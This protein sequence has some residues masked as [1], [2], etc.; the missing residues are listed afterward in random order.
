M[1]IL[2]RDKKWYWGSKGPFPSRKK[3]EKVAQAAHASGYVS[4]FLDFAIL[5][6]AP[7]EGVEGISGI[8]D[9][10]SDRPKDDVP[11]Q[12]R[13][14]A[15][16]E[17]IKR[18]GL[19]P[20][21]GVEEGTFY[22][23]R[24]LEAGQYAA[25][26]GDKRTVDE[27]REAGDD[28]SISLNDL[29]IK[30][31]DSGLETEHKYDKDSDEAEQRDLNRSG[32]GLNPVRNRRDI[33]RAMADRRYDSGT[34]AGMARRFADNIKMNKHP[35]RHSIW[36]SVDRS[37]TYD[38]EHYGDWLKAA[39]DKDEWEDAI[40]NAVVRILGR[41]V[42]RN[43]LMSDLAGEL[44][45]NGEQRVAKA[46]QQ[47][48]QLDKLQDEIKAFKIQRGIDRIGLKRGEKTVSASPENQERAKRFEEENKGLSKEEA[49]TFKS[50]LGKYL[51][52]TQERDAMANNYDHVSNALI[53]IQDAN[54]GVDSDDVSNA[55][56]YFLN[57][58]GK[59]GH[60]EQA[61]EKRITPEKLQQFIDEVQ[62]MANYT[63][64][65]LPEVVKV[66]RGNKAE[67]EKGD[68]KS[69]EASAKVA[70]QRYSIG[71][72]V[73]VTIHEPTAK[74]FGTSDGNRK[75]ILHETSIH[76]DDIISDMRESI[77]REDELLISSDVWKKSLKHPSYKASG[78]DP[79]DGTHRQ[80]WD[81]WPHRM[82]HRSKMNPDDP[83]YSDSYTHQQH[84]LQRMH[85]ES[86]KD[87]KH[88]FHKLPKDLQDDIADSAKLDIKESKKYPWLKA[89]EEVSD[90]DDVD[91]SLY[92]L[93]GN[94]LSSLL[95]FVILSKAPPFQVS[96][97]GEVQPIKPIEGIQHFDLD[98]QGEEHSE[99]VKVPEKY[100]KY[101]QSGDKLPDEV[102]FTYTG[103]RQGTFYDMRQLS[104]ESFDEEIN[105]IIEEYRTVRQEF[106][107][108]EYA[109][110]SAAKKA[111]DKDIA[112][113][114]RKKSAEEFKEQLSELDSL[115]D[116]WNSL[117]DDAKTAGNERELRELQD[118]IDALLLDKSAMIAQTT[119]PK[120][121]LANE[122]M[123]TRDAQIAKR[124]KTID[125]V[126][127]RLGHAMLYQAIRTGWSLHGE[128]IS[129]DPNIQYA[130]GEHFEKHLKDVMEQ[131]QGD[132]W[133][134]D[135][136]EIQKAVMTDSVESQ[137]G[138]MYETHTNTMIIGP[139]R[140]KRLLK[141]SP[142]VFGDKNAQ[143][144][145]QFF[146][147]IIHETIHSIGRDNTN[148][149]I[150]TIRDRLLPDIP[151]M[152]QAISK[153]YTKL[154]SKEK[155]ERLVRMTREM[156]AT[157]RNF[158]SEYPVTL[159]A[160][161]MTFQKYHA[162]KVGKLSPD[163]EEKYIH[164]YGQPVRN[165]AHWAL[166]IN[167]GDGAKALAF[168]KRHED[169]HDKDLSKLSPKE[170]KE[171][172]KK[173]AAVTVSFGTYLSQMAEV[174]MRRGKEDLPPNVSKNYKEE[175]G[176]ERTR[177]GHGFRTLSSALGLQLR[178]FSNELFIE[179][180]GPRLLESSS[181][182]SGKGKPGVATHKLL[183]PDFID[184]QSEGLPDSMNL[185]KKYPRDHPFWKEVGGPE[186][187]AQI[188]SSAKPDINKSMNTDFSIDVFNNL[189][190]K[191]VIT[192]DP[193]SEL[194]DFVILSKANPLSGIKNI[195]GGGGDKG[196]GDGAGK[197]KSP[198]EEDAE[199]VPEGNRVYLKEGESAPDNVRIHQGKRGG[200]FYDMTDLT[201]AEPEHK[202]DDITNVF[203]NL[204]DELAYLDTEEGSKKLDE[205][206]KRL[207][208]ITQKIGEAFK[209][210]LP[211]Y[212]ASQKAE[213]EFTD[214]R[215]KYM[216]A[217]PDDSHG[218]ALYADPEFKKLE[219]KTDAL[220][221]KLWEE[222]SEASSV[223]NKNMSPEAKAYNDSLDDWHDSTQ[224]KK[225]QQLH[226]KIGNSLIHS[227][228]VNG[229][230][231][232]GM[233]FKVDPKMQYASWGPEY[234]I[235]VAGQLRDV[236]ED[237][238]N[239]S[240]DQIDELVATASFG[241]KDR[242]PEPIRAFIEA[243]GESLHGQYDGV[244]KKFVMSPSMFKKLKKMSDGELPPEEKTGMLSAFGTMVHE[245]LH[246]DDALRRA[247][248]MTDY[249]KGRTHD[250]PQLLQE[251][252]N[253]LFEEA[254]TE[255]LAKAIVGR[256]YN[257]DFVGKNVY[258]DKETFID[259]A[260]G[261][262][263]HKWDGYPELLPHVA[264]W[265]LGVSNG[266]PVKA[267]ALLG[268]MRDLT[269]ATKVYAETNDDKQQVAKV[270]NHQRMNELSLSFGTYMENYAKQYNP[271]SNVENSHD[272]YAEQASIVK[273]G[274]DD[275][276]GKVRLTPD[277]MVRDQGRT[278]NDDYSMTDDA[279]LDLMHLV[280]GTKAIG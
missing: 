271:D 252:L 70:E 205:E 50:P 57:V 185:I 199:S 75:A 253:K 7:P 32:F 213:Q 98:T 250:N 157:V 203:N 137:I 154:S 168:V 117:A 123:Q 79:E 227:F 183:M 92:K 31:E 35:L 72:T 256:K 165:Y 28:G 201:G 53:L 211:S 84:S 63:T 241:D 280:Y 51:V 226:E 9:T 91:K 17:E 176:S 278:H 30:F 18:L 140:W 274:L 246:S 106:D 262:E 14:Y 160:D 234:D 233:K 66:Y 276:Y 8:G 270:Q 82:K 118:T 222:E 54:N 261:Q 108:N 184:R 101:F 179:F 209:A 40:N 182:I 166:A 268:E 265:T 216:E 164:G 142:D 243:S 10:S 77:L 96:P 224:E 200:S 52:N 34:T 194:L 192:S 13:E 61:M 116:R 89:P 41:K 5:S 275:K 73:P 3:A 269:R 193:I 152:R 151:V 149:F 42:D 141:S 27:L 12:F 64:R 87:P 109:E 258:E 103:K 71:Q 191:S 21:T 110:Y 48:K 49:L 279:H 119:K 45:Q 220:K 95:D 121:E 102:K 97:E 237:A 247:V 207:F 267:R 43:E 128:K 112:S 277:L 37:T 136:E 115:I 67:W 145:Y 163:E 197:D 161:A 24:D 229:F 144:S 180:E 126:T 15:S 38:S 218:G 174:N 195:F 105:T 69:S 204:I 26:T 223:G 85:L 138:G 206:E 104:N 148:H 29:G 169:L 83:H 215:R 80:F 44:R 255:L 264:K 210:T 225:T 153:T 156:F 181:V 273:E 120:A 259:G 202:G 68:P 238:G 266:D 190:P 249:N 162:D 198:Q 46:Q 111:L 93:A 208:A 196:L 217:N 94:P 58:A 158:H 239:L 150:D 55:Y 212:E 147:G 251:H 232:D 143:D 146:V 59:K 132:D 272:R 133:D 167:D 257:K 4:K 130:T 23:T 177:E 187:V 25:A 188:I 242:L 114:G 260:G 39:D 90:K 65:D 171:Q 254:P 245:S 74:K 107:K 33:L 99:T 178:K 175:G 230:Q 20:H 244:S 86:L 1:P 124:K 131:E 6:K 155:E 159:I 19:R 62:R 170:R 189:L 186:H 78:V 81:K 134:K 22:D 139:D 125:P 88:G 11:K 172:E 219:A 36:G 228:K 263:Q 135:M 127:D 76:R 16:P 231:V 221:E 122:Y 129:I 60:S 173:I 240:Q 56:H 2:Q 47:L 214:F 248:V 100:R 235:A 113:L 236:L